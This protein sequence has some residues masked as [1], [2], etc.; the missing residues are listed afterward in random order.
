MTMTMTTMT[1]AG[2]RLD[3]FH[4]PSQGVG[5]CKNERSRSQ[6]GDKCRIRREH[7]AERIIAGPDQ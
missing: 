2:V 5:R 1:I 6:G 7:L 4:T 3:R